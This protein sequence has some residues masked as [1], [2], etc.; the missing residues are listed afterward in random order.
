MWRRSPRRWRISA[1]TIWRT[2][3]TPTLEVSIS[4][5]WRRRHVTVI[6]ITA[7]RRTI[8]ISIVSAVVST[9]IGGVWRWMRRW[10]EIGIGD[11][12]GRRWWWWWWWRRGGGGWGFVE[13]IGGNVGD[14]FCHWEFGGKP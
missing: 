11:G 13:G 2:G 8:E 3:T 9:A 1:I 5:P 7:I 10:R 4:I 6:V 14:N 12:G